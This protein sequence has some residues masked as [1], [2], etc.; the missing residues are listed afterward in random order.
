ME[1]TIVSKSERTTTRRT[2]LQSALAGL[3]AAG[4]AS[5]LPSTTQAAPVN[6]RAK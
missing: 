4:A 1:V 5:V 2:A 6:S 3:L